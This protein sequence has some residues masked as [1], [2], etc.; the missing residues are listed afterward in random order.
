MP[1]ETPPMGAPGQEH[2]QVD[3]PGGDCLAYD[4]L[5]AFE[6]ILEHSQLNVTIFDRECIV[7]DASRSAA[8]LARMTRDE[9]RGGSL[10]RALPPAYHDSLARTLAGESIDAQGKVPPEL[11]AEETWTEVKTLPIRDAEGIVRGGMVIVFDVSERKR[12]EELI[13]KLA[14][15][16]AVTELPNR[17]M[18]SMMLSR[19]LSSAAGKQRQLAL[20]WLN[21][22]RFKDVN[23][24]LGQK[25]GDEVLRT[26][27]ER[28]HE[29][30][31]TNDM[32][33]RVGDDDFVLLLPRINSR[34]H[35][36]G[37]TARIH[38][39]FAT[40]FTVG[41]EKVVLTA[42]CGI[43][44]HPGGGTDARQL[45]ENAR[46]AMRAAKQLG[47]GACE[48]DESSLTED[49]GR[50]L[51]LAGE[52]RDGIAG[53]QFVV[54]YQPQ[55]ALATMTVQSVE[56]LARWNHPKRGL[57]PP[58][59]F[60]PFAEESGLIVSLGQ[61]L[62]AQSSVH[63]KGWHGSLVAPPRLAV[64]VSAREFQR[65]DVCGDLTRVAERV[66][67]SPSRFEV[68]ITETAV[69]ADPRHAAEVAGCL[70]EVGAS[71][72]LDDFGTGY[73]S[74]THLRDLPID[75][76]KIDRSFVSRC[77][78]DPSAAAILVAVT[79]L[80]HELGKK[81]VA[82]GA[83]TRAQLDFVRAA[84]C[85]SVQGYY[86]ARPMPYDECSEYLRK[87]AEGPVVQ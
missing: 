21:V 3:G 28:L 45:Q 4:P 23:D 46:T 36:D 12:A 52:I 58:F 87:A 75:R 1:R 80:A 55:I 54:H 48:I 10:L 15:I 25:A 34:K 6:T 71:V 60:I 51:R 33:A 39:V 83:E 70:R 11:C 72:A 2:L 8:A 9:M 61:Y 18:L 17:A 62:L 63:L 16:D 42:S 40:P 67:L 47:G 56:A 44:V 20:V 5:L 14:F 27:G 66:G 81:V 50:R 38:G 57:V 59:E 82:E 41:D 32:V 53:D 24:G 77:L 76:V 19:A 65:T 43:A 35:L 84:G 7:R 37:L 31:R 26:V 22:D 79:H 78:D 64:N 49:S 68:E 13:E 85:D 73:S 69:L 30:V 74:L 86:L 29:V